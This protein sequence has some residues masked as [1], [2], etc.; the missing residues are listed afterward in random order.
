MMKYESMLYERKL[1]FINVDV[2]KDKILVDI[3]NLDDG[4][5]YF[6]TDSDEEYVMFHE[7]DC[8]ESVYIEDICGDLNDL[9]NSPLLISEEASNEEEPKLSYEPES[10]MWT[11]YKFATIKGSVTIRWFG[12]SN[13]YYSEGVSFF[14]VKKN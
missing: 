1:Q 12:E 10:Y 4:A 5:M 2:L 11:F 8:C 7:Q 13:G 6:K 14:K 3:K 9:L